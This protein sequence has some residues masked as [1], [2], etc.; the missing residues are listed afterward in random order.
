MSSYLSPDVVPVHVVSL[1]LPQCWHVLIEHINSVVTCTNS[2]LLENPTLFQ[3]RAL[4]Q[5][6][7]LHL[8]LTFCLDTG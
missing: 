8:M 3:N 4:I 1:Q 6:E 2:I 7:S 5:I